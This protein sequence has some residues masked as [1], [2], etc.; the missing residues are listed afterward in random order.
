MMVSWVPGLRWVCY[1]RVV[2][3]GPNTTFHAVGIGHRRPRTVRLTA[4]RA[5]RLVGLV[6]FVEVPDPGTE[7]PDR[8]AVDAVPPTGHL[9][10]G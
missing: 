8:T 9:V 6:P 10:V 5:A 7:P 1:V 4:R 3:D 2:A